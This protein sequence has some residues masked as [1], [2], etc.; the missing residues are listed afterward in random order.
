[1]TKVQLAPSRRTSRVGHVIKELSILSLA[2]ALS[3]GSVPSA[4]SATPLG[5][6]GIVQ[7]S[8]TRVLDI[9]Q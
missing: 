6:R 7:L 9:V 1:V 3:L 4:Q 5:P 2:V 8:A